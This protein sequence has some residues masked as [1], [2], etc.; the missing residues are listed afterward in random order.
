MHC[1]TSMK[2]NSWGT[3]AHTNSALDG[4]LG[5]RGAGLKST[6]SWRVVILRRR[7]RYCSGVPDECQCGNR[8]RKNRLKLSRRRS[9]PYHPLPRASVRV[10]VVV[11]PSGVVRVSQSMR[12]GEARRMFVIGIAKVG[13]VERSSGECQQQTRCEPDVNDSLQAF[14]LF[15]CKVEARSH[16]VAPPAKSVSRA[17]V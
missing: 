8:L 14:I 4:L 11:L 16:R 3:D 6:Q 5:R 12:M 9:D 1:A 10:V 17:R 7:R 15:D 13:M 2:L